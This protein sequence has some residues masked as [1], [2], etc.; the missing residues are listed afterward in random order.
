[1]ASRNGKM[2]VLRT[3]DD[4]QVFVETLDLPPIDFPYWRTINPR[5]VL[6]Q[7][8]TKVQRRNRSGKRGQRPKCTE[9]SMF[10]ISYFGD[11]A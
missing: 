7:V 5:P 11:E 10:R 3:K 2:A 8:P 1:M 9:N 4:L 6:Q